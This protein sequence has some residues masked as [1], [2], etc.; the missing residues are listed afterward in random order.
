MAVSTVRD[1]CRGALEDLAVTAPGESIATADMDIALERLNALID[2]WQ[3][4]RYNIYRVTR[5]EFAITANDAVYTIGTGGDITAVERPVYIDQINFEDTSTS[6]DIELP[7]S[8]LTEAAYAAIVMKDQTSPYPSGF[9][10]N[11]TFPT[12][13]ITLWPVPTSTTLRLVIYAPQAIPRYSAI[14]DS[15][16]LPPGF[17][18]FCRSSLALDLATPF[19]KEPSATLVRAY[20][21]SKQIVKRSNVPMMDLS[22]DRGSM[23]QTGRGLYNI[24][25]DTGG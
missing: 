11:P 12:G 19:E 4:E 16:S 24:Y 18:R 9:Y 6:P 22:L 3:A 17:E 21:E 5:T 7:M 20:A 25:T 2:Q 8:P 1:V 14:S 10:Y 13:T 23:I 15:F